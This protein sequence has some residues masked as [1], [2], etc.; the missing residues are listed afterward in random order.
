MLRGR[1][2]ESVGLQCR[3]CKKG[4]FKL[5]DI[6]DLHFIESRSCGPYCD[7]CTVRHHGRR[8]ECCGLCGCAHL[9]VDCALC[10]RM[11]CFK[12]PR[13]SV[14][15]E[16]KTCCLECV[17]SMDFRPRVVAL[18]DHLPGGIVRAIFGVL[19]RRA[20]PEPH[21]SALAR[22]AAQWTMCSVCRVRAPELRRAR[23]Y[24]D[25]CGEPSR[26]VKARCAACGPW[27]CCFCTRRAWRA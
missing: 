23:A 27:R 4:F 14:R 9:V 15:V 11:V 19:Q 13:H 5:L 10:A 18:F 1:A 22:A 25:T 7:E 17:R 12:D 16:G 20:P 2:K 26:W 24:C 8:C 3:G 6:Y 21:G